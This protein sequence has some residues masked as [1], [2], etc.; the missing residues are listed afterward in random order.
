MGGR[1][2][3][4]VRLCMRASVCEGACDKT[5]EKM[6]FNQFERGGCGGH[7]RIQNGMIRGA[8]GRFT[9][10]AADC[11]APRPPPPPR[12]DRTL[13]HSSLER[14]GCCLPC[15]VF[16]LG[17]CGVKGKRAGGTHSLLLH[18]HL[19][20]RAAKHTRR[21]TWVCGWRSERTHSHRNTLKTERASEPKTT[22]FFSALKHGNLS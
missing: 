3:R 15:G 19:L 7:G 16:L 22:F 13:R 1:R 8:G 10:G 5:G 21:R 12:L 9:V 2:V 20:Q 14:R 18:P 17:G 6:E 4:C 11:R